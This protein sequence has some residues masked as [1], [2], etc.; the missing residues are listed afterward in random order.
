MFE[1]LRNQIWSLKPNRVGIV[2]FLNNN[3]YM[4][5]VIY[6]KPNRRVG[7]VEFLNN[8]IYLKKIIIQLASILFFSVCRPTD[9]KLYQN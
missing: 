5:K 1:S 3:I 2:E 4:K 9:S 8:S 6:L 7:I